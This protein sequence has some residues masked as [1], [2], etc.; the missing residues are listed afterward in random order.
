[1]N[2]HMTAHEDSLF[3]GVPKSEISAAW[4]ALSPAERDLLSAQMEHE[5]P[6]DTRERGDATSYYL[7]FANIV[8]DMVEVEGIDMSDPQTV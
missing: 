5:H 6:I 4:T 2:G 3:A 8:R 7:I 1:M